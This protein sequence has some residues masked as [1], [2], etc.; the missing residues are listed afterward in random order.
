MASKDNLLIETHDAVPELVLIKEERN[1]NIG[2]LYEVSIWN[3]RVVFISNDQ[4]EEGQ[5]S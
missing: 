5:F 4:C 2:D 1:D 3:L